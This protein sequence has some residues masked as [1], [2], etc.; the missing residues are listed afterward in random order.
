MTEEGN[1]GVHRS[2]FIIR[3]QTMVL[4]GPELGL[5]CPNDPSGPDMVTSW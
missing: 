1:L 3:F 2:C 5:E 4:E